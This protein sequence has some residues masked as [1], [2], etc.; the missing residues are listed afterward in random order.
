MKLTKDRIVDAG[1]ATF[2]E[3]GYHDLSMRQVA[4]RLGA[5]AGSLYYHVANKR[6]LLQL[7]ADRVAQ[8]AY[9]A[10]TEALAALPDPGDWRA[11]IA[12]QAATLRSSIRAHPGGAMLL[13]ESPK[14]LSN[15]ALSLMERL[16]HTLADAGVPA[17]RL[18]VAADTLLSHVTGF[19]L[20]EQSSSIVPEI[21]PA[22]FAELQDRFPL[23]LASVGDRDEDAK[24]T[25]SVA[26]LC[27]AF[28]E[29]R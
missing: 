25:R 19:V 9:D 10:G 5:Q 24:F 4:D 20:Q 6:V 16:L 11:S 17:A 7:M 18:G 2:A 3:V 28:A 14:T 15:G 23:T 22:R 13:A 29:L 26:L 21:T 1:M 12:A 8:Q 27:E